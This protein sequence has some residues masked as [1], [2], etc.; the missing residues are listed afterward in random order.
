MDTQIK[1]MLLQTMS[2]VFETM[3][4]SF[5]EPLFEIPAREEIEV[6]VDYINTIISYSGTKNATVNFYFPIGLAKFITSNFLGID[7]SALEDSQVVDTA[8]E[9]ANMAIGSFLGKLDPE[10][11]CT[12]AI[13]EAN[14]LNDFSVD[15][16]YKNPGLMGFS[17]EYGIFW[18]VVDVN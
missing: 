11:N 4:F 5:L 16:I 2:E 12:L 15:D 1:E 18:L 6:S 10:G 13:P 9:T 17:T 7:E 3:F 14:S 8:K